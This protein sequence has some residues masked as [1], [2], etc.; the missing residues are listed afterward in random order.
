MKK[1]ILCLVLTLVLLP[2]ASAHGGKTDA[3]GSHYDTQTGEYHYHH[4]YSAHQ[5][6]NGVC[7]YEA[8]KNSISEWIEYRIESAEVS[9]SIPENHYFI[10]QETDPSDPIFEEL[11]LGLSGQ[12]VIEDYRQ[13]NISCEILSEDLKYSI[14]ITT[15]CDEI[16]KEIG[17]FNL[18]EDNDLLEIAAGLKSYYKDEFGIEI[19]QASV[20]QSETAKY[21]KL[22]AKFSDDYGEVKFIQ[23]YTVI[24][25][26]I[27]NITLRDYGSDDFAYGTLITEQIS[28]SLTSKKMEIPLP[29]DGKSEIQIE[30]TDSGKTVSINNTQKPKK[31]FLSTIAQGALSGLFFGLIGIGIAYIR[32]RKKKSKPS[33]ESPKPRICPKC[34]AEMRKGSGYCDKCGEAVPDG[35]RMKFK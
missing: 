14:V 25:D 21:I 30:H 2:C 7:P 32:N 27:V 15:S 24:N 33:E 9:I 11:G 12:E 29:D 5:H 1:L 31:E 18:Y 8:E 22:D 6:P 19:E 20:H 13:N 23:Y 17:N 4:G 3:D 28:D 10:S 34:G 35:L 26:S 16:S